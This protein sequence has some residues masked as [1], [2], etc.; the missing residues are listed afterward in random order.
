MPT[1]VDIAFKVAFWFENIALKDDE[2]LQPQKMHRLLFISQAYYAVINNGQ[3][4]MPAVLA[5][6][7]A[8]S[9]P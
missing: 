9:V 6:L 7:I 2:Y 5:F 8:K 1:D 4:L 3:K